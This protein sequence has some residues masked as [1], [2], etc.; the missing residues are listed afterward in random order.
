MQALKSLAQN[1]TASVLG[2]CVVVFVIGFVVAAKADSKWGY[3]V[4]AAGA[5]MA[6]FTAKAAGWF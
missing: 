3:V 1:Q 5:G 2:V 6:V 4:A